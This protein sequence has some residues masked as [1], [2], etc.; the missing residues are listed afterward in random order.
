MTGN[1]ILNKT[2]TD[3][4]VI[5]LS[6]KNGYVKCR[7]LCGTEKDV[8]I[9]SLISGKSIMCQKCSNRVHAEQRSQAIIRKRNEQYAGKA[10]NEWK[11]I[12]VYKNPKAKGLYCTAICPVCGK[13]NDM[14]LQ[15][16]K[17]VSKCIRCTNNI[18]EATKVINE[19]TGGDGSSLLSVKARLNGVVNSN[20]STGVNGVYR[21]KDKY[22]AAICFKGKRYYL[23]TYD[24]IGDAIAARK[25]ANEEI[26]GKYL[27]EHE[28]WEDEFKEK[29]KGLKGISRG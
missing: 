6:E 29:I 18:K 12:K 13:E 16:I 24:R 26:Y 21:D 22:R 14:M 2:F 10:V 15:S 25:R 1:D 3:W 17:T 19:I 20:S 7:C 9:L 27:Q 5:G 4:T 11:I 28:G 8:S 23:G